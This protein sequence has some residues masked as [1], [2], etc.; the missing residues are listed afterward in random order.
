MSETATVES[1]SA[2]PVA[3]LPTTDSGGDL[4]DFSFEAAL[5][6]SINQA[7][8]PPTETNTEEKATAPAEPSQDAGT[9]ET[10]T[11]E[12]TASAEGDTTEATESETAE[13]SNDLLDSLDADVGDDWTPKASAAFQKLKSQLK[14]KNSE[15][16][17]LIQEAREAQAKVAELEGVVG[18][19]K[20]ETLQQRVQE[21][22]NAQ[23]VSNLEQTQ[24]YSEAVIAPLEQIFTQVEQLAETHGVDYGELVDAMSIEDQGQQEER[25]AEL[26]ATASDRDRAVFYRLASEVEPVLQRRDNLRSNAAE[27]LREAELVAE[28]RHKVQLADQAAN[29]A[30]VTKNVAQRITD[31]VPF[32]SGFEG[33]D[34]EGIA[35]EAAEVDPSV[36]HS[37]DF[38]YQ[39]VAARLMPS[40]VKEYATS[41]KLIDE[42]TA[43]LATYEDAE[44]KLSGGSNPSA[45]AGSA[46]GSDTNFAASI[47]AALGGV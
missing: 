9:I 25:V 20:L 42:L 29:R 40:L 32:L 33:L 15:R 46:S 10:P 7:E 31:K 1:P 28:E 41:Q 38:A 27:A 14:E 4:G 19:E 12:V 2:D 17:T 24:A 13:E 18:S 35:K 30:Q 11:E 36:V 39:A 45:L 16:E 22:E 21:Y 34:M 5:E 3:A 37:V 44:P 47:E 43:Q 6:A 8:S 23:L 26:L